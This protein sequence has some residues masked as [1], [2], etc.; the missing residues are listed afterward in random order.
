M[1][2]TSSDTAT[3]YSMDVA[4]GS[5]GKTGLDTTGSGGAEAGAGAGG[6]DVSTDGQQGGGA[7][8]AAAGSLEATGST[9]KQSTKSGHRKRA[10]ATSEQ[11]AVLE[12]VFL[13]NRSPASRLREDLATR[14]NMAPRQVQVWFQNRR[15]KEKTQQRAPRGLQHH[16]QMMMDPMGYANLNPEFYSMT[17]ASTFMAGGDG[18]GN[19]SGTGS[20]GAGPAAM[21]FGTHPAAAA[22]MQGQQQ[23]Q[24]QHH[25]PQQHQQ[26][27]QQQPHM[28]LDNQVALAMA[29]GAAPTTPGAANPWLSW[30]GDL[31]QP[32]D[33]ATAGFPVDALSL[34]FS[35]AA[36]QALAQAVNVSDSRRESEM[37]GI[38]A[39][40]SPTG[41]GSMAMA[42]AMATA[43]AAASESTGMTASSVVSPVTTPVAGG[44]DSAA[45]MAVDSGSAGEGSTAAAGGRVAGAMRR[46][47]PLA[48]AGVPLAMPMQMQM[49]GQMH[50]QPQMQ[51]PMPM[52]VQYPAY[53]P[54]VPDSASYMVLDAARLTVGSWHRVPQAD[55]ELT[56]LACVS[57]PAPKPV[58]RPGSHRPAELDALAGEFQWIIG[59]QGVRYKMVLPYSAISRIKFREAPDAAAPLVDAASDS[60]ANPQAALALLACALKNPQARGELA[61]HVYDQ[62]A[63]F[64]QA[65]GGEWRAIGDFSENL[66]ASTTYVH[67][68]AGPFG[69][70]FCQLRVLLATCSRL[71]IAADP[72]MALWLGNIDDPYGAAAAVPPHAWLPCS[73]GVR[74]H[75]VRRGSDSASAAAGLPGSDGV[76]TNANANVNINTS[77]AV[78]AALPAF[79]MYVPPVSAAASTI[80][81]LTPT[82]AMSL[83]GAPPMSATGAPPYAAQPPY[84]GQPPLSAAARHSVF[85][86]HDAGHAAA[87]AA[88]VAGQL[89]LK[90]QRS[91]SLPFIRPV[92]T[93]AKAANPSSLCRTV[94]GASP[95]P[96]DAAH[97]PPHQHAQQQPQ[98]PTTPAT[99]LPLRHR[100]SGN[101][102]RR[103]A[104]Y[105]VAP[106]AGS[107]VNSPQMSPSPFWYAHNLRRASRESLTAGTAP[108]PP[109]T[110]VRR[111]SDAELALAM[112]NAFAAGDVLGGHR[113]LADLYGMPA[114]PPSPLS[115]VTMAAVAA[116]AAPPP[117]AADDQQQPAMSSADIVMAIFNAMN[118]AATASAAPPQLQ[119]PA[120]DAGSL[121]LD[122]SAFM[123]LQSSMADAATAKPMDWCFDWPMAA[124]A[125]SAAPPFTAAGAAGA[126]MQGLEPEFMTP[127]LSTTSATCDG[128]RDADA[129]ADADAD[130]D[131]R[132]G[133]SSRSR[134]A[135]NVDWS[136]RSAPP[137]ALGEVAPS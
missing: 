66:S 10:R 124:A 21:G 83:T 6:M 33:Q 27:Q 52:H 29:G 28:L 61:I 131:A 67:T 58:Q 62:P 97:T 64:F 108:H 84:A 34:G 49:P 130:G 74:L 78:A 134:S 85:A 101:H 115:N 57:P 135:M 18:S 41:P 26:Q 113:S 48:L 47:A 100:A 94:D 89:P 120:A 117:P 54:F 69:A 23:P 60:V 77:A 9:G 2:Q 39:V 106:A 109:G 44:E 132:S 59:S 19:S 122:P 86:L 88:A 40:A 4:A 93:P 12:S 91:A 79:N 82:S 87:A 11:V 8:D 3:P 110:F 118:S 98:P 46:P 14:L 36:A 35:A 24:L 96:T 128:D 7:H 112:N 126:A 129:D 116:A 22:A 127:G 92:A 53:S 71:K 111:E 133:A 1:F 31:V 17:M 37:S 107:R 114:V 20:F 32:G 30:G 45:G 104:P 51:A 13:V 75:S 65:D 15:A 90:T 136:G 16:G 63:F 43:A 95:E 125:A 38:T 76:S 105:P 121:G 80:G 72:L 99:A 123:L 50:V 137:E 68:V 5:L 81:T 55:T 119:P 73:D 25:Q 103:P 56:C 70:L 42:M 102:L